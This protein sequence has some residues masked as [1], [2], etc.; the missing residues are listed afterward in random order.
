MHLAI[1]KKVEDAGQKPDHLVDLYIE[2]L[3]DGVAGAPAGVTFG[4]H[5]CRGNFKGHYLG[6]G[7][8]KSVAETVLLPNESEP[9]LLEYDTEQSGRLQTAPFCQRQRRGPGLGQRQT[10]DLEGIDVLK[11][12]ITRQR[13]TSI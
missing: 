3:N 11:R 7:G 4:V 13:N 6:V 5:M 12:R 10:P 8:M 9:F 1:R 2:S